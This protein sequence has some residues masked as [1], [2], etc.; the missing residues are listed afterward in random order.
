[1]LKKVWNKQVIL[2]ADTDTRGKDVREKWMA[3][4]GISDGNGCFFIGVTEFE[5]SFSDD[6]WLE[7]LTTYYPVEAGAAD[8]TLEEVNALHK[9]RKFSDALIKQIFIRTGN[10]PPSK[11]DLGRFLALVCKKYNAVPE[12]FLKCVKYIES[13]EG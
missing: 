3:D 11:P 4:L 13:L 2:L 8:W 12:P 10:V 6:I 5:D 7:V 9:E 1:M